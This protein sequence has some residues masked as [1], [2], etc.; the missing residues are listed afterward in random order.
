MILNYHNFWGL[1][2]KSVNLYIG[3]NLHEI[4][5]QNWYACIL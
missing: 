4:I 3:T 2:L 1:N 5:P